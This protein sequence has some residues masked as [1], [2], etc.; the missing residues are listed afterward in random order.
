S[1]EALAARLLPTDPEPVIRA[2]VRDLQFADDRDVVLSLTGN[3][4]RAATSAHVEI[5]SHSPL[6]RGVHRRMAVERWHYR[7]R[8]VHAAA[9]FYELIVLAIFVE[10]CFAHDTAA[11]DAPMLLRA[12]KRVFPSDFR[13]P[14]VVNLF[15]RAA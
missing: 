13:D 2:S 14:H 3:H 11:F 12:R 4:A 10:G 7:L 9:F 6:L 1:T 8:F 5:D 15:A